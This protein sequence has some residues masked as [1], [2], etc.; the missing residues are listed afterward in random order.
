[1]NQQLLKVKLISPNAI[2]PKRQ[3]QGAVGYDLHSTVDQLVPVKQ[4]TLIP[5]NIE[6]EIPQGCYGRI[7][8][9]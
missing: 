1:M 4:S 7:A 3:S 5:I 6:V 2:I 9:R 8:P